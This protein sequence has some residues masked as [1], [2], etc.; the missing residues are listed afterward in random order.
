MA[1]LERKRWITRLTHSPLSYVILVLFA[2]LFVYNAIGAY[3]KSRLAEARMQTAEKELSNLQDQKMKLTAELENANTPF[4]QE[5]ALRE[6]FN[7]IKEGE[8]VIM[9]VDEKNATIT[10]AGAVKSGF[11]ARIFGK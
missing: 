5:K 3:H 2:T 11:W 1:R 7:V 8:Q 6:K 9:I 10:P 4:G